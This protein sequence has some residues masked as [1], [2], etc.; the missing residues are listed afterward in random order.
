MI[1][2]LV[3][4]CINAERQRGL[5]PETL[6]E[7]NRYLHEFAG[8]CQH[9]LDRLEDM[10]SDFLREYVMIRGRDRGSELKKAVVWS[11]RK[12]GAYMVLRGRLE[13]NPAEPLRHPKLS[14]RNKLPNYL[15]EDE[16]RTLLVHAANHMGKRDFAVVSLI[17]ATGMRPSA[18]A[19]LQKNHFSF[20]RGYI[21]ERLKGGGFKKTALPESV[22]I[23]L[24]SYLAGRKDHSLAL[25]LSDRNRPV[26]IGWIQR[27]VKAAG[28][29]AGLKNPLT[30]NMLRHTFAVHAADRHGKTIT[31]TLM[32]HR[33]LCTTAVYTHLSA[34]HFRTLMNRHPF[35]NGG[36]NG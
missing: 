7:L 22:C 27:M 32:G 31:K 21:I 15:K 3:T 18:V 14:P 5:R 36:E 28:K 13:S 9:K 19:A 16:L 26:S 4:E 2:G 25:F 30:C 11:L 10:T 33:R 34:R 35:R 6:K 8:Y 23:I 12:F 20:S 29:D 24:Q 17:A 1:H